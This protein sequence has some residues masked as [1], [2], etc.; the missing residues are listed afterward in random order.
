MRPF[1][2]LAALALLGAG[3]ALAQTAPAPAPA[4]VLPG[5]ETFD[6]TAREGGQGYRIYVSKPTQPA[7]A[8]GFPV[9]YVLDANAFFPGFAGERRIEEFAKEAGGGVIVVGVGYPHDQVYDIPARTNDLTL[10]WTAK[11]P[12]GQP[13]VKTGGNEVFAHFLLDQLRPEIARRYPVDAKR[14]S[15]FGHSLGGLFALHMLYTRPDAFEA[16]IAASPSIWW[17]DKAIL[18]EEKAFTDRLAAAKPAGPVSRLML[19]V[20]EKDPMMIPADAEALNGRLAALGLSSRFEKLA[21]ET[22]I[23]VP[24]RAITPTFRFVTAKP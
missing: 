2:C 18:A 23:T 9:L 10:P 14:Q 21:G 16:I 7:P 4:Y 20:G 3:P 1:S 19:F 12:A 15:L 17:S 8:G 6:L 11:W 22:H 5:T 13:V 24:Y